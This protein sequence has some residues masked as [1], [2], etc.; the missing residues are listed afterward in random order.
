MSSEGE[1]RLS[2]L[3][4]TSQDWSTGLYFMEVSLI[5]S[6]SEQGLKCALKILWP[7]VACSSSKNPPP[8]LLI[9]PF[10]SSLRTILCSGISSQP[11]TLSRSNNTRT[12]FLW[13]LQASSNSQTSRPTLS[14]SICISRIFSKLSP[15][16]VS[17][18][19]ASV[20]SQVRNLINYF[21]SI[22]PI[23]QFSSSPRAQ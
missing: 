11:R 7:R 8:T 3:W 19:K 13:G 5:T 18:S 23:P 6:T 1:T 22:T 4:A 10:L 20:G 16:M 17:S 21:S 14:W 15:M 2:L 9:L 12:C